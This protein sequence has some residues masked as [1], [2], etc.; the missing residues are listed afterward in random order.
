M[1]NLSKRIISSLVLIIIAILF[2]VSTPIYRQCIICVILSISLH[3]WIKISSKNVYLCCFGSL[4]VTTA[5]LFWF[6]IPYD[7][8]SVMLILMITCTCDTFAYFGGKIFKGPK[9][10]P[11]ISPNKT[12]SGAICGCVGSTWISFDAM[13]DILNLKENAFSYCT[14][15]MY[16]FLSSLIAILGDLLESKVKRILNIKDSGHLIPG[17]GGILD[18]ID[19]FL[20]VSNAWGL[21][22]FIKTIF[23]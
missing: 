23:F 16:I 4:Y 12:I 2:I 15:I 19:S 7:T 21:W 11:L 13:K 1:N 6:L 3:E 9:L 5:F 10:A 14:L 8:V 22:Y 18:R 17:H 20:A